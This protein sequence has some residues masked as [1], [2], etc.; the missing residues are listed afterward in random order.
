M[1]LMLHA[2]ILFKEVETIVLLF[3]NNEGMCCPVW[4]FATESHRG[5]LERIG[6]AGS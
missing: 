5:N 1:E 4:L 3:W 2:P 6:G